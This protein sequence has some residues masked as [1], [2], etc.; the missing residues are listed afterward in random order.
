MSGSSGLAV[1]PGMLLQIYEPALLKWL[2]LR[3]I[4]TQSFNLAFDTEVYR[5]YDEFDREIAAIKQGSASPLRKKIL[6]FSGAE[7]SNES[8]P[9]PF[10][11]AVAF[12]QITQWSE[13]KLGS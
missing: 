4:P 12:G 3:R 5:Q 13:D 11:Q 1:S 6:E 9:I 2:Y 10:K 7:E 8:A